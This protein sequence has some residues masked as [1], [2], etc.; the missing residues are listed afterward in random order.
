MKKIV[1]L[2]LVC[3]LTLCLFACT[4]PNESSVTTTQPTPG[5][6]DI[7]TKGEG[8]MT[9][10]QYN[11][12]AL[13]TEVVIEGYIQAKQA[14]W[15]K[16]GVGRGTFYLQDGVGGY[17]LYEMLCTEE[18]YNQLTIGTKIRVTGYKSQWKGEVEVI[19]AT[20]E[21]LEGNYVAKAVDVTDKL[22]AY[23]S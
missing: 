2:L 4:D 20:Y 3:T 9:W 13:D 7:L 8:V 15:A 14:W 23:F 17:L 18:E 1:C 22:A 16:E 11:A 6:E 12:A 5:T 19:D 10:E 21:I